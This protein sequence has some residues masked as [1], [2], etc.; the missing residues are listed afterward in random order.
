MLLLDVKGIQCCGLML[1]Q[2][3]D[4]MLLVAVGGWGGGAE[5]QTV[6]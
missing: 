3:G 5:W 6:R 4:R 1:G 2:G